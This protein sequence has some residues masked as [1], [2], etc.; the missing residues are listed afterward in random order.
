MAPE[1]INSSGHGKA[2]D[3]WSL[4]VLIYEMMTG[5]TPFGAKDSMTVYKNVLSGSYTP[6]QRMSVNGIDLVKGLLQGKTRKRLG[7]AGA[8]QVKEHAW[9]TRIDFDALL[10]M[11]LPAPYLPKIG[12]DD[13]L[14]NFKKKEPMPTQEFT[15]DQSLFDGW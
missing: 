5:V 10:A 4:G 7:I 1:V 14:R 3:F 11:T 13:D 2:A 15:G 6:P 12:G 8:E 9:F